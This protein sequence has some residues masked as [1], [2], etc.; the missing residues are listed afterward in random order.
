MVVDS[1]SCTC[2][3]WHGRFMHIHLICKIKGHCS[4]K[5]FLIFFCDKC[6]DGP[7]GNE[8]KLIHSNVKDLC[9]VAGGAHLKINN[10]LVTWYV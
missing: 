4:H 6:T 5:I 8:L 7:P 9:A 2:S 10:A 1:S 3:C